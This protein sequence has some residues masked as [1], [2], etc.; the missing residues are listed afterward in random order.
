MTL[1]IDANHNPVMLREDDPIGGDLTVPAGT[2]WKRLM[3]SGNT[4]ALVS[5]ESLQLNI[6]AVRAD[7]LD[8]NNWNLMILNAGYFQQFKIKGESGGILTLDT[9][10]E[11]T[12]ALGN[13]TG[14]E[15]VIYPTLDLPFEIFSSVA[16]EIG[17]AKE[18]VYA[19]TPKKISGLS[20]GGGLILHT[21]QV[22]KIF[23]KAA[24]GSHIYWGEQRTTIL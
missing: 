15:Y 6:N 8:V 24:A 7:V 13:L 2:D 4:A 19:P 5:G 1:A 14:I 16:L 23:Y 10:I 12:E 22:Q 11:F 21:R 17:V 18:N 20:A 9:Q 3:P